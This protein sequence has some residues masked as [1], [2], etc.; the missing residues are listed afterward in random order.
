MSSA[1]PLFS[2]PQFRFTPD[3]FRENKVTMFHI[4][5]YFFGSD[6]GGD[7]QG[8]EHLLEIDFANQCVVLR[9]RQWCLQHIMHLL[10]KRQLAKLAKANHFSSMCKIVNYTLADN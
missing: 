7:Q 1:H 5:A 2:H 6:Q 8:C 4:A 3:D 9:I 10:V